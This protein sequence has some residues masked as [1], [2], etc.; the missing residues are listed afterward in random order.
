MERIA[1]MV[2]SGTDIPQLELDR[3]HIYMAPLGIHY[4]TAS[5]RDRLDITTQQVID[6]LDQ[7]IP[8]TSLPSAEYVATMFQDIQDRG[9][10]QV[11]V[12]TISP[13]L[14]GAYNLMQAVA[15]DFPDLEVA[16]INTKTISIAAG[17]T[18][19]YGAQLAEQGY[20]LP[21]IL[22]N[23]E[24]SM[25]NNHGFFTVS[26]LKY[27]QQ[28]GRIGLIPATLGTLLGILP[29]L[30]CNEEGLFYPV[31]KVRGK[32]AAWESAFSMLRE[33]IGSYQEFNLY[34]AHGGEE[35]Q[36]KILESR[37]RQEFPQAKHL[38]FSTVSAASIVHTGP[39][40][41]GIGVQGLI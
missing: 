9:I 10:S 31:K 36:A 24:H 34:V 13:H 19:I 29:I 20:S 22:E 30:S 17:V 27:L 38:Y 25:K 4:E 3:Y 21:E 6:R 7:E 23:L 39:G 32:S 28:G 33:S 14:S 11:L 8:K 40:L 18:A 41:V 35:A 2:D 26:T 16:F 15:S 12:V 37:L 1:I 5:Y